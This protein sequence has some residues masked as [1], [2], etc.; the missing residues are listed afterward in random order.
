MDIHGRR[1]ARLGELRV[2]FDGP[3]V[4]NTYDP[5][6]AAGSDPAGQRRRWHS[7]GSQGTFYEGAMTAAGTFPTDATDQK[8]QANVVAAKY[9]V[10]RLSVAPTA[11]VE[12]APGLQTFAPGSSQETTVTFTNTTGG[13]RWRAWRSTLRS[14][15][16]GWTSVVAGGNETTRKFA[17]P[18]AP[19]A[20]V[21]A[22]FKVTAGPAAFNGDLVA[23][24]SWTNAARQT[25]VEKTM[26]K[27]RSVSPIKIN[28]FAIASAAP[29][30]AT[31]SYI[32][33][34]NAGD[35][36]VNISN[37]TLTE[38]A[39]QQAIF[40]SIKIP[41]GTSVA[42]KDFYLLALSNSG[43]AAAAHKGDTTI[44]VP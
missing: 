12:R 39:S 10:Q 35:S 37:W 23:S 2:M 22:I 31:N 33:L 6:A 30:N 32:E 1:C 5:D 19:G 41:A 38:H 34:Y 14:A 27:V 28:E 21:S 13:F 16:P 36:E 20:A 3:R 8:V 43:L 44:Y 15:R 42:P 7:N 29:A 11:A 4:N 25:Q 40:S 18:V 26:E 17:E 9:D 24:A